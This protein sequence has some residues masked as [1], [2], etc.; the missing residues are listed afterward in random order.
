[1][2]FEQQNYGQEVRPTDI[3]IKRSVSN[4]KSADL[5]SVAAKVMK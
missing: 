2:I 4:P 5:R 3:V 1:M